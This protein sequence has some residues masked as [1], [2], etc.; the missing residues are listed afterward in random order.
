MPYRLST[1]GF[2]DMMDCRA[3]LRALFDDDTPW[4]LT[5][6]AE[7][8]VEFFQR[9]LVDDEGRPACALVRFFKTHPYADLPAELQDVVQ[10]SVSQPAPDLRCLTLLATRGDEPA[11]NATKS[12][13][14]HRAIP[15]VSE[16]MVRQA[17]MIAQLITQLGLRIADV[18]RPDRALMLEQGDAT[19]NVFHVARALGSPHIVAQEEFVIPYAI[20]SVLGFGGLLAT[21]DLFT[22]IM[23]S[24]VPIPPD[25]AD[26]FRVVAL[27]LKVAI[28]P[29]ARKPLM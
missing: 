24:K 8:A 23:F 18:V 4:T 26:Q 27:N 11:W 12:S 1:F 14:G 15:L 5:G 25:V 19:Y 28:L 29:F 2:N 7:R 10:K 3:R 17:P 6:A 22:V 21:G 16:D 20:E 9:E 13:R